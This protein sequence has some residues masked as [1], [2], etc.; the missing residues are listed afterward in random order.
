MEPN[1]ILEN[2]RQLIAEYSVGDPD[3]WWNANRFVFARLMLDERR[4]L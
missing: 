4:L 1:E 3:K 2:V